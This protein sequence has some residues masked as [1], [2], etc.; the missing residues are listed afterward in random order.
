MGWAGGDSTCVL[1]SGQEDCCLTVLVPVSHPVQ[2]QLSPQLP[3]VL[4][5]PLSQQL[6]QNLLSKT[7]LLVGHQERP[8]E[9][10]MMMGETLMRSKR[11]H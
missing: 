7:R 3:G 1:E 4:T 6:L 8:E 2:A 10:E 9:E 5:L 11:L